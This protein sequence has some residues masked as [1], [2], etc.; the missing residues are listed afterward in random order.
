MFCPRC[1]AESAGSDRFCRSCGADLQAKPSRGEGEPRLTRLRDGVA[2]LIGR[3]RCERIITGA[4]ALA[5]AV[6]VISFLA[7]KTNGG[8]PAASPEADAACVNAKQ[9]VAAV[10]SGGGGLVP[11]SAGVV[12]AL[13]EFQS[14]IRR[15][16]PPADAAVLDAALLDATVQ[17]G[18]LGRLAGEGN[19]AAIPDQ[20]ERA[21][22]ATRRLDAA[23]E[24]LG[25][26]RCASLR[27]GPVPQG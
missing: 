25:L 6:A 21:G 2:R 23:I 3:S 10:A 5:V 18:T 8:S 1:G 4:T 22:A 11:Y 26:T 27:V 17:I 12:K 19:E 13:V 7:L 15:L 9:A 16:V 24:D 14:E 20:A